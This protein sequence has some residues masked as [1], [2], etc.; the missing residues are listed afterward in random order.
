MSQNINITVSDTEAVVS[1]SG[2]RVFA[3]GVCLRRVSRFVTGSSED[4]VIEIPVYYDI[5]TQE[6]MYDLL[7]PDLAKLLKK[8]NWE[9]ASEND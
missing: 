6:A 9:E 5:V 4:T 8:E 1:S 3:K 7:P 2:V